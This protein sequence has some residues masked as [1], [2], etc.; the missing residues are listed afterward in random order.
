MAANSTADL[1]NRLRDW[2]RLIKHDVVALWIAAGDPRTPFLA[3]AVAT[4][5]AAYAL[6]PIDLIPDFVPVLGYLDDIVILP[7]GIMLAV[8]LIPPTLMAEYREAAAQH[9]ERP[10]SLAGLAVILALWLTM[11][12]LLLWWLWPSITTLL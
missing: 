6:S 5:V 10:S 11:A 3:T 8:R 12:A 7:L 9:L 2:A 4:A 1:R